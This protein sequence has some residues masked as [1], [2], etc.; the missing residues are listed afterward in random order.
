MI[1]DFT[2]IDERLLDDCCDAFQA[3]M[4]E[5]EPDSAYA[6]ISWREAAADERNAFR[7]IV[8]AAALPAMRELT[9]AREIKTIFAVS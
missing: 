1:G 9:R 5:I 6:L 7:A 8:A 4:A 2:A 3:H